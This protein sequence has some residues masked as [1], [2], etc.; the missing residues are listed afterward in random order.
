MA[1]KVLCT[2]TAFKVASEALQIFGGYGL[3][4]EYVIE[5]IFRDA[6]ASMIEDG[7]NNVLSLVGAS[8]L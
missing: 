1:C 3:T 4:K 2:E 7:E 5:K 6:R 8:H